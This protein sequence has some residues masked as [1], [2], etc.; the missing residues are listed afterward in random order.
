MTTRG[1]RG[2]I[3]IECDTKDHILSATKELLD[4]ILCANPDLKRRISPRH[5]LLSPTMW[6]RCIPR[7][8]RVKW[9]GTKSR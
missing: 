7:W 3:T 5:S 2:A 6:P 9:A 8:P 4:A 1:I